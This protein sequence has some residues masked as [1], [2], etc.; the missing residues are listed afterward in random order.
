MLREGFFVEFGAT[1]G[2][3]LSNTWLLEKKFNWSGILA[4]P[5]KNWHSDLKK[6]SEILRLKR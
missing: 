5:G 2:V 1:D 3:G 6:N 4:E